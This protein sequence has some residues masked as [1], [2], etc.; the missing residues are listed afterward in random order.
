MKD[1]ELLEVISQQFTQHFDDTRFWRDYI[2]VPS[3]GMYEGLSISYQWRREDLDRAQK[4]NM[5]KVSINRSAPIV[6]AICGF[7]VQNRGEIQYT[8]RMPEE[9]MQ[10]FEDI[11]GDAVAYIEDDTGNGF[12]VSQAFADMVKCGVGG[13][14]TG[15]S[16]DE[17][18]DGE[19]EVD[20]VFPYFLLWDTSAS[21]KKNM[22]GSN[23]RAVAIPVDEETLREEVEAAGKPYRGAGDLGFGEAEFI[24]FCD[25]GSRTSPLRIMFEYQ[26]REKEP[27]YRVKN[28]FKDPAIN[29][30]PHVRTYLE[31][32]GNGDFEK[33]YKVDVSHD[34]FTLDPK[35]YRQLKKE[36]EGLGLVDESGEQLPQF[37][38]IKQRKYKYYRALLGDGQLLEKEES[39][40][41]DGFSINLM[42]GKWSEVE[43]SHYGL[44]TALNE[45]Q[46]L[47]NE[48]VSNYQGYLRTIPKGGVEIERDAVSKLKDFIS[49]Y[50]K[51][52]H[53]T[54]YE[55][56]A[57]SGNKV[58]PKPIPP[59]PQG[60]VDMINLSLQMFMEISGVTPDFMG[61][62]ES[63]EQSAALQSQRVRQA[64]TVL[65]PYFDA[66]RFFM[67]E[68]GRIFISC[69][70]IMAENN[71]GRLI[72]ITGKANAKY[73]PLT[74]DRLAAEYDVEISE[75]SQSPTE[76]QETFEK[77]LELAQV[78]SQ[79]GKDLIPL[80]L[81][82]APLDKGELDRVRE[83]LE[84]PPPPEPDPVNQ[85]LIVSQTKLNL[86]QAMKMESDAK[87]SGM[88]A[89]KDAAELAMADEQA[90]AD[91]NET[92]SKATLNIAKAMETKRNMEIANGYRNS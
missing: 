60:L 15:F 44:M 71:P 62:M 21:H 42:T 72:R 32:T 47:L 90:E 34:L 53:V 85:G 58:R 59:T 86:A 55:P 5:P 7:E 9:A 65:A 89:L 27:I 81:E 51:A 92:R 17:N 14:I 46:F 39:Y 41:Q 11:I 82:Y 37:K 75:V 2:V 33:R 13:T 73:V 68:Q 35:M 10:G 88:S 87:R 30:I 61:I 48:A 23:W 12:E 40:H 84:P 70:R 8:A 66:R 57:L 36:L 49:T 38:A 20:R 3:F 64:L 83:M 29:S 50:T 16:Y 6:D 25:T 76:R 54:V 26:W 52:D 31:D 22:K 19:S 24:E 69:V 79:Q 43:K 77:L 74:E 45:A 18:E 28:G 4:N 56:G 80:V 63:K 67:L 78:V 91:V 1:D